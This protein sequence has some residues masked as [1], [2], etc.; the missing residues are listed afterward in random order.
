LAFQ[1][2]VTNTRI[3]NSISDP[4]EGKNWEIIFIVKKCGFVF[5]I[6]PDSLQK[7][8]ERIKLNLKIS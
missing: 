8:H 4:D 2:E 5:S 6:F 1:E 7:K 3:P